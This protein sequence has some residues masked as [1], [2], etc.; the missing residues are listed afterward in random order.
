MIT[1]EVAQA[2][3]NEL[4]IDHINLDPTDRNLL[5]TI[6]QEFDG[7]P[8][9]LDTLA[10]SKSVDIDTIEDVYKPY[11]PQLDFIARTPR[12]CTMTRFTY[13]HLA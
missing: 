7:C 10:A 5:F 13:T 12:E 1:R 8:V 9:G 3:L 4:E 6:I 2:T 11:M